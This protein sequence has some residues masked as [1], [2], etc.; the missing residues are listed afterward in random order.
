MDVFRD[1]AIYKEKV[2][3]DLPCLPDDHKLLELIDASK[4]AECVLLGQLRSYMADLLEALSWRYAT[5]QVR[6]AILL[7]LKHCLGVVLANRRAELVF[8]PAENITLHSE[9]H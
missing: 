8:K 7:V 1:V 4:Q 3:Q 9:K 5:V 2:S 6:K